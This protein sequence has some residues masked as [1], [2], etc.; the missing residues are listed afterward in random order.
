MWLHRHRLLKRVYTQ[1]I[2]GLHLHPSLSLPYNL[3]VKF[4]GSIIGSSALVIYINAIPQR[5][6][7]CCGANFIVVN[8]DEAEMKNKV[9]LLMVLFDK[10]LQLT[11]FCRVPNV[12]LQLSARVLINRNLD[13]VL[14]V[15][16]MS[17]VG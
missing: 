10:S 9:D 12:A 1:N 8:Y 15:V 13:D 11:P 7:D 3:V 16:G 17:I 6:H 14:V 2:D 4:H 5:F